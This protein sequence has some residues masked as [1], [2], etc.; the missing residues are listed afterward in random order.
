M[1]TILFIAM[2]LLSASGTAAYAD[3]QTNL[4]YAGRIQDSLGDIDVGEY[5]AP[6]VYDWDSDGKKD[7]I[8]GQRY[9][10]P[11]EGRGGYVSYYKNVGTNAMPVFDSYSL[12]QSCSDTC[13]LKVPGFG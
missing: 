12:I 2:T 8:V 3:Y 10:H 4:N 9:D 1:G 13:N 6:V 7:L 11:T 5:S